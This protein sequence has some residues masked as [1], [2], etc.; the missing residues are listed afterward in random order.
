MVVKLDKS[1][2]GVGFGDNPK[3]VLLVLY[4]LPAGENLHA[5]LLIAINHFEDNHRRCEARS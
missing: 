5:C 4:L 2:L 1:A 3:A